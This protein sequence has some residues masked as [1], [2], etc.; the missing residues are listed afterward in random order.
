MKTPEGDR[1]AASQAAVAARRARAEVKR[2]VVAGERSAIEV[3]QSGLANQR[4]AEGSLRVRELLQCIPGLGPIRAD[5][6]LERLAISPSKR[7]GGLGRHQQVKLL[8]YLSV[9]APHP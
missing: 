8:D 4:S 7:V 6:A 2:Q 9:R 1:V 3:V 5:R